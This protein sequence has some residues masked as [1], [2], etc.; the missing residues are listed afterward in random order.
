MLAI[1]RPGD[2]LRGHR[3]GRRVQF[4]DWV[5]RYDGTRITVD[6]AVS[7]ETEVDYS[8]SDYV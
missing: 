1:L 6:P 8:E 5:L 3:T 7:D 2:E 4:N